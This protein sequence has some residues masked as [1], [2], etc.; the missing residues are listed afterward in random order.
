MQRTRIRQR[1]RILRRK[2]RTVKASREDRYVRRRGQFRPL[3]ADEHGNVRG[4]R[5]IVADLWFSRSALIS[6]NKYRAST[7]ARDFNMRCFI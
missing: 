4:V 1:G 2:S 5:C 3:N 7:H 6:R